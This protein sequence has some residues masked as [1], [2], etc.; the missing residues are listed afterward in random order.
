MNKAL[1]MY[2]HHT[3]STQIYLSFLLF[4]LLSSHISKGASLP[5]HCHVTSVRLLI[6][7]PL[8]LSSSHHT[9]TLDTVRE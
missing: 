1:L 9:L 8:T 7:L 6:P 5:G 3:P 4:L 2:S